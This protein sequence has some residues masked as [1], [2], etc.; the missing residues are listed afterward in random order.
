MLQKLLL[1]LDE[2]LSL[3]GTVRLAPSLLLKRCWVVG[4][5]GGLT[6]TD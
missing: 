4:L 3:V 5:V 2:D 1:E 6:H